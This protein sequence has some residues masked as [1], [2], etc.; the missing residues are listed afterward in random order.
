MGNS[1]DLANQVFGKLTVIKKVGSDK[2]KSTLW[3]CECV[4]GNTTIVISSSLRSG[5]TK[6]CGCFRRELLSQRNTTHGYSKN[7]KSKIYRAWCQ[8]FTRCN[9]INIPGYKNYGGR[10][11]KI[12]KQWSKFENFLKDMGEPPTKD[13]MLERIDNNRGYSKKN[14]KW[15]TRKEQNRNKRN[16]I[17]IT[18]GG[19]TQCLKD[20]ASELKINYY[21]LINRINRYNWSIEKAFSSPPRKSITHL[22][23]NGKTQRIIDWANELK[24]EPSI[25]SKRLKNG[26]GVKRALT[27]PVKRR[28]K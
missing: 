27:T 18:F 3:L 13:H 6:S 19:K 7:K 11:I 4:C 16:I 25:L 10:G 15:G 24:L 22:T 1:V 26:W 20:W 28:K 23:F 2:W 14:C 8:M 9:N 21:T 17:M 5:N 12:C